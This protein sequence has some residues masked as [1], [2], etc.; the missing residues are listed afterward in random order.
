MGASDE[1][2]KIED[3]A[4]Q[5]NIAVAYLRTYCRQQVCLTG[6]CGGKT[7]ISGGLFTM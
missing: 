3:L 2:N 1:A 7:R 4:G 5:T 6:L